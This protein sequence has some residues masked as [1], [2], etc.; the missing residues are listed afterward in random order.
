MA[1]GHYPPCTHMTLQLSL[2]TIGYPLVVRNQAARP[3]M[4][5]LGWSCNLVSE[6]ADLAVRALSCLHRGIGKQE[7]TV[8]SAI[9]RQGG[10]R[11]ASGKRHRPQ[12]HHLRGLVRVG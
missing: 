11:I 4:R 7:K 10:D 9:R 3:E 8:S 5:I 1:L 12:C 2:S 6:G